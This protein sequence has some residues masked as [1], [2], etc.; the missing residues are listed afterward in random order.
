MLQL[1]ALG[2]LMCVTYWVLWQIWQLLRGLEGLGRHV[3]ALELD[4]FTIEV[5]DV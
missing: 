4:G 1:R 3:V 2:A 5:F